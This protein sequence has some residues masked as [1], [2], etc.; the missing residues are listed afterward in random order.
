MTLLTAPDPRARKTVQRPG[1]DGDAAPAAVSALTCLAVHV[2]ICFS[3]VLCHV[4]CACAPPRP[5][6]M[7]ERWTEDTWCRWS[8]GRNAARD[9]RARRPRR[10]RARGQRR[11]VHRRNH[12][13]K[14]YHRDRTQWTDGR[15]KSVAIITYTLTTWAGP[16]PHALPTFGA[17]SDPVRSRGE[18]PPVV[19]R[20][21]RTPS[22]SVAR[23]SGDAINGGPA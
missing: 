18:T 4:A 1:P 9:R 13:L 7:V 22:G 17:Q 10:D 14:H 23:Q 16:R 6:C 19:P 20:A 2:C 3:I 12:Y 5:W 11:H 21:A 15:K 8:V